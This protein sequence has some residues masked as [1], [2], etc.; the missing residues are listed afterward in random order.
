[1]VGVANNR[2]LKAPGKQKQP[3][4]ARFNEIFQLYGVYGCVFGQSLGEYRKTGHA[5]PK[6]FFK[7]RRLFFFDAKTTRQ[8]AGVRKARRRWNNSAEK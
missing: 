6:L 5:E 1:V 3:L 8:N 4:R 2:H 7:I